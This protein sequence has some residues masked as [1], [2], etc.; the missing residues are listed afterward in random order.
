MKECGT[1]DVPTLGQ[2]QR[3]QA[4]LDKETGI[5]SKHHTSSAGSHFYV[6]HPAKLFALDWANPLVRKEMQL[7]P[8]FNKGAMSEMWHG[9]KWAKEIPPDEMTPMW[10]DWTRPGSK[11]FYVHEITELDDGSFVVPLRWGCH[12]GSVH[13]QCRAVHYSESVRGPQRRTLYQS[14]SFSLADPELF[15]VP[16]KRLHRNIL[17]L[18]VSGTHR[19]EVAAISSHLVSAKP[20]RLRAK[21]NG[22]PMY[23]IRVMPWSD[24]VS[25][26]VSKQYNPHTNVYV[27]NLSLPHKLLAQEYFVRFSST[28]SYASS[29]EQFTALIDDFGADVWHTGYDCLAGQ[30]IMFQLIPHV[31]PADNPQQSENA[32]HMGVNAQAKCRRD[33][34]AGSDEQKETDEG[35]RAL[36]KPGTNRKIN[37]TVSS[38]EA[39]LRLACYGAKETI[40]MA[41]TQSGV[42]DKISQYWIDR[43]LQMAKEKHTVMLKNRSTR[44]PRLNEVIPV[45]EDRKRLVNG[46]KRGI[47]TDLWNWLVKQPAES[48]AKL[49]PSDPLR[50]QIRPGDHYNPLLSMRGIDPHKD[51]PVEI[52]HTYLLGNSKYVWHHTNTTWEKKEEAEH[53]FAV[54]LE[55]SDLHGLTTPPPRANYIV[56]YKNSLIGKHFK[57]LSQLAVFHLHGLCSDILYDMWKAAG[58]LGALIWYPEINNLKEYLADLQVA[59]DNVLNIWAKIDP[60]KI[61]NKAKLHVLTHLVDDIRRFGPAI[62]YGTEVFECWNKVFRMCSVL[63]NH[64]SPSRDIAGTLGGMERFKHLVSGGWWRS[65]EGEYRQ[66]GSAISSI[67]STNSQLQRQLG[68]STGSPP[69][70]GSVKPMPHRKRAAGTWDKLGIEDSLK[71]RDVTA[72]QQ[73]EYCTHVIA[74][75][76]DKCTA[77]SWV[78]YKF[79]GLSEG[80]PCVRAGRIVKIVAKQGQAAHMGG[81]WVYIQPYSIA[82]ERHPNLN[83]PVLTVVDDHHLV[84]PSSVLFSFNAQH[85]CVRL[86]CKIAQEGDFQVQ[87]R[88][89]TSLRKYT[90]KHAPV[91]RHVINMH[92]LHNPHLLR[93][94]LPRELTQPIPYCNDNDKFRRDI[95]V[96]LRVIGP[97]KRAATQEK[98]KAT[99]KRNAEKKKTSATLADVATAGPSPATPSNS[100]AVAAGTVGE[101]NEPAS[102]NP[103]RVDSTSAAAPTGAGLVGMCGEELDGYPSCSDSEDDFNEDDNDWDS[104]PTLY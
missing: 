104:M 19:L 79:S 26:N 89:K 12:N 38:I 15:M 102:V 25:G 2:L 100:P 27:Q 44:D 96:H 52:L 21:A 97:K 69:V 9:E 87:E 48:Y 91:D 13:A 55:C 49:A 50:N 11:H 41:A 24:D 53:A 45:R 72:V 76:G 4:S 65:S 20:N 93:E 22:K 29:S 101:R 68:W 32:S 23:R 83:M 95:A 1:P 43:L 8:E 54:R 81:A 35:Y 80:E 10:Y 39:Q 98:S 40:K 14:Q 84:P 30:E 73:W 37:D 75:S 16:V 3:L 46:I 33:M 74:G 42:K 6:N 61:I 57:I 59:I 90:V 85:D 62:L 36:F 67:L 47:Q 86:Q 103:H 77:L 82:A 17:D 70:T 34:T 18:Q 7:Y 56:Q 92:S 64:L 66:A 60:T 71:P 31:L 94:T 99:R 28:S 78:F 63:S 5:Q 51:T 58:E 88:M